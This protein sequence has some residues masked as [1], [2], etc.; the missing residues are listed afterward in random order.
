MVWHGYL[1]GYYNYVWAEVLDADAFQYFKENGIFNK[2][3]AKLFKDNV[4]SRGSTENPMILYKRFRGSEP[5]IDALLKRKGF[6]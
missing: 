2:K 5:K 6:N 4:I 3:I 1:A